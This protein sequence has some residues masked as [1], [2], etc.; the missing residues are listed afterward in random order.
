MVKGL[1]KEKVGVS[2]VGGWSSN[3]VQLY[4][5]KM[6]HHFSADQ[7]E[8]RKK[9]MKKQLGECLSSDL[10]LSLEPN[11]ATG[12]CSAVLLSDFTGQTLG[13]GL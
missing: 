10:R 9:H 2:E 13:R 12:V 6:I 4:E 8:Q 7:V 1:T 3:K 5:R 11:S